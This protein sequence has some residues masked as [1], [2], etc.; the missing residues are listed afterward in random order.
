MLSGPGDL[1]RLRE[2]AYSRHMHTS[3]SLAAVPADDDAWDEAADL[4]F[5]RRLPLTLGEVLRP[6]PPAVVAEAIARGAEDLIPGVGARVEHLD[7]RC[8]KGRIFDRTVPEPGLHD[9][10]H[11]ISFRVDGVEVSAPLAVHGERLAELVIA[12]GSG[13]WIGAQERAQLVRYAELASTGLYAALR[14]EE[15]RRAAL[16]DQLTGLANRRALDHELEELCSSGTPLCLLLLDVDALKVVNDTLGY[17]H[18][19]QLIE[20]VARTLHQT[21]RSGELA[22]RLGGDEFVVV[23]PNAGRG[24]AKKRAAKIRKAFA[25]QPLPPGVAKLSGGVT[26]GIIKAAEGEGARHLVRRAAQSMRS[27]KRRR[28]SDRGNGARPAR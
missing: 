18:G 9:L 1:F 21:S 11:Q 8:L 25:R 5:H 19:D 20:T 23:L 15:L 16:T 4:A 14:G 2:S 17:D 28:R 26:F 22:A 3:G 24:K 10:V 13:G 27:H 7:E 12:R 6:H